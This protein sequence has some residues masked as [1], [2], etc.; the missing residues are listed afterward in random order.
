MR[1]MTLIF[2]VFALLLSLT[3]CRRRPLVEV[4]NNVYLNIIIDKDIV[5]YTVEKDPEMM[6]VIFYD[7]ETGRFASQSF[8]PHNG[9]Y[10]HVMPG[11]TYD[12][13]VY[14]FDTEA[15][16]ISNDGNINDIMA[17]T[18]LIPDN[19]RTRLKGRTVKNEEEIIVFE[20]DHLFVGKLEDVYIPFRGEGIP[21]YTLDI[22]AKTVVETWI[23][24]VD[25]IK[26]AEYVGSVSSVMTGLSDHNKIGSPMKSYDEAT[27]F[28]E[29]G[30][31]GSDGR[32]YA[33]F[34]TFGRNHLV[35]T[36]QIFSLVI[37]D[38]GGKTWSFNMDV[39]KKF[40]NNPEQYIKII[41]DDIDIPK[42]EVSS[43]GG[44]APE[45]DEWGEI[46]TEIII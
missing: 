7:A 12:I 27:V 46:N 43:G 10:V 15:T 16:V 26:G 6:R 32:F 40:E 38:T 25:K 34:N 29:A 44:L 36:N 18:N 39:S 4:D 28:F 5:N 35:T 19:L 9:G 3:G 8:L 13:L 41:T 42:P 14:N 23:I 24:E 31:I 45:V 37:T 21:A 1:R 20:P 11:K 2:A 22:H 30:Q 33:K 17:Y